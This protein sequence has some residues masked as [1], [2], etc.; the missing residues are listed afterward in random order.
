ML[1][2]IPKITRLRTMVRVFFV[3]CALFVGD[4]MA[5]EK[6]PVQAFSGVS[7]GV[8]VNDYRGREVRLAAPAQRVVA[9]APHIVENIFSA[10]G[11]EALVGVVDYCDFPAAAKDIK[12]VGRISS[13][14]LEA[15]AAVN[16]DLVVVWES[17][18]AAKILS[19]LESL[20]LP[21]YVSDPKNLEDVARSIRDFGVLLGSSGV[22]EKAAIAHEVALQQLRKQY[23]QRKA[24]SVLYQVWYEPLQTLNDEHIISDVIRLCG[25]NNVFGDAVT[26]APKIS[27]EAVLS[28]DPDVIIASGMGE[29][30][31]DWLDNW[32]AW[33]S[34]SAV[35]S[36]NLFFIPPDII[37]RH[38]RRILD[39]AAMMC[40]QLELARQK[41]EP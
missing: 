32:T 13:A 14:S 23:S 16:P 1:L 9:L 4:S 29:A 21:V 11:G 5:D 7:G 26:L 19:K 37:Q 35:K 38:T 27:L 18:G 10:G 6:L 30:R 39:G 36:G 12:N 24:V 17:A 41:A 8:S 40:E 22:A 3:L 2:A 15:I 33:P 20:G 25:G 31:P 34:L 28:R